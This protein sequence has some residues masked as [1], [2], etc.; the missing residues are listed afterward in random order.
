MPDRPGVEAP[1]YVFSRVDGGRVSCVPS[2]RVPTCSPELGE[3]SEEAVALDRT[4]STTST[5]GLH[6]T[7]TV[8]AKGGAAVDSLLRSSPRLTVT[9]SSTLVPDPP[10]RA[11]AVIDGDRETGWVA[12]LADAKPRLIFRWTGKRALD[13]LHVDSGNG[14]VA[15]KP[16]RVR[17]VSPAGIRDMY[18]PPGGLI[19]FQPLV[20][21]R[22]TVE[23]PPPAQLIS[24]DST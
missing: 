12:G 9:A 10:V 1:V 23:F 5:A 24:Q 2:P 6:V 8:R 21:D 11:E 18:I 20:T 3:Q 16:D 4:F 7:G 15:T 19:R 14:L 22:I 13:Q 17:L